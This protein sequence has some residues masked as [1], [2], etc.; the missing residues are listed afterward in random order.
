MRDEVYYCILMF[1]EI[2]MESLK[3]EIEE[4]VQ[5]LMKEVSEKVYDYEIFK[6]SGQLL[7]NLLIRE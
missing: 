1:L 7:T 6:A 3:P 2:F 4:V 5:P